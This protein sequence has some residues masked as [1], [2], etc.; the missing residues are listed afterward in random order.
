MTVPVCS[1]ARSLAHS[2]FNYHRS[3]GTAA[4][5]HFPPIVLIIPPPARHLFVPHPVMDEALFNA[6][7]KKARIEIIPLID[8]VFFLL[9]TFVL[10]TLSLQKIGS[11]EVPLPKSDHRPAPPSEDLTIYLQTTDRGLFFWRQG[12]DG[13][14][15]QLTRSELGPRLETY[16]RSTAKPRVLINGDDRA[17][18]SDTIVALDEVRKARIP[19][20]SLET[21]RK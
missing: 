3:T 11:I 19:E 9:A 18:F 17:R 7:P 21:I 8:V 14:T 6:A 1:R 10:F 15:E 12:P 20:V 2:P 4:A 13:H 5:A 16:K